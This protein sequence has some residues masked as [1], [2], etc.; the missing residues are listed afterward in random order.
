MTTSASSHLNKGIKQV[1]MGLPQGEKVQ[2]MYI[3]IDGTGE[4]LRCKTRTLDSEPKCVEGEPGCLDT[5]VWEPQHC[6]PRRLPWDL[7]QPACSRSGFPE[8]F[9]GPHTNLPGAVACC[10]AHSWQGA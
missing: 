10:A 5:P 2:A 9:R 8:L 1:Y 3:W 6:V 4:G 7:P